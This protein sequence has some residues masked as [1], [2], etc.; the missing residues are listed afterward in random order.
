MNIVKTFDTIVRK[1]FRVK[2]KDNLPIV[3]ARLRR[4]EGEPAIHERV[5]LARVL[6]D[7][8]CLNAVEIG[9]AAGKSSEIWVKSNPDMKLTCI[10]PWAA[11]QNRAIRQHNARYERAIALLTPYKNITILRQNSMDAIDKFED[12]SLDFVHVDG[13][14]TFDHCV[15]DMIHW[16]HK[17]KS[18]GVMA[19]HDYCAL[20]WSGVI[21]AVDSFTHCHNI[22]PWY[23]TRAITPTA[24]WVKP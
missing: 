9:V 13:N 19:V 6:F 1:H 4:I 5:S 7:M 11:K 24:F 22:N 20:Q 2:A 16:S 10:D 3:A 15:T 17:L 21:K 14:H 23:V 8:K 12:E 18:G